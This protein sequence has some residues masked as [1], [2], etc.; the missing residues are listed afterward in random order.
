[1]NYFKSGKITAA[2][3]GFLSHQLGFK[4]IKDFFFKYNH[5]YD[6]VREVNIIMKNGETAKIVYLKPGEDYKIIKNESTT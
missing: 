4:N 6:F 3:A 2:T 1:M 5:R